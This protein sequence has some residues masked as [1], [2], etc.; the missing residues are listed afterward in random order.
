MRTGNLML[1]RQLD[2]LEI[3]E[4]AYEGSYDSVRDSGVTTGE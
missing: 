2:R 4:L 1:D 3:A